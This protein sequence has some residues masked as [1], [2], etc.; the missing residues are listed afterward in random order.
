MRRRTVLLVSLL[1][2]AAAAV[3]L[4]QVTWNPVVITFPDGGS[5]TFVGMSRGAKV[6]PF[7][8]LD[9]SPVDLDGNAWTHQ[10]EWPS[11][12]WQERVFRMTPGSLRR[13]LPNGWF[14]HP[15][16]ELLVPYPEM[17]KW[18]LSG[19][20]DF[21]NWTLT[22]VDKNGFESEGHLSRFGEQYD[23][24]PFH[25][26][27]TLPPCHSPQVTA[28]IRQFVDDAPI[29]QWPLIAEAV[30]EN[31]CFLPLP[32]TP[33]QALPASATRDG[34]TVTLQSLVVDPNVPDEYERV[35]ARLT[36]SSSAESLDRWW[37]RVA[38][39]DARRAPDHWAEGSVKH[40]DGTFIIT[41]RTCFWT[42]GPWQVRIALRPPDSE[43]PAPEV[44]L[45]KRVEL[46]AAIPGSKREVSDRYGT[47]DGMP[48]ALTKVEY[49]KD[50]DGRW[51]FAFR[52]PQLVRDS[53]L[54][55]RFTDDTGRKWYET[56][57]TGESGTGPEI[58]TGHFMNV[59]DGPPP[60]LVDIEMSL[61]KPQLK[62]FEFLVTPEFKLAKP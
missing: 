26:H 29:S 59:P 6:A 41:A 16:T 45:F 13:Y 7:K 58:M 39:S 10:R 43:P 37:P 40:I 42:D 14:P 23:G 32:T 56:G 53:I 57:G 49:S 34:M 9:D 4:D 11:T 12:R 19:A 48:M 17:M 8:A 62:I 22:W 20:F 18:Q 28:R 36:V 51:Y 44:L 50:N 60:K 15:A 5:L 24:Y 27:A 38:Y 61:R 3:V 55:I 1:V 2:V 47:L 31:P 52:R 21:S 46:P 33:A 25:F 30:M 35:T 54:T